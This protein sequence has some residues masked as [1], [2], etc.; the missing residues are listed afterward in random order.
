M[1][2]AERDRDTPM[3]RDLL[4]A[5]EVLAMPAGSPVQLVAMASVSQ[6][7][8]ADAHHGALLLADETKGRLALTLLLTGLMDLPAGLS[9]GLSDTGTAAHGTEGH[10]LT[11]VAFALART[12]ER[13]LMP[14]HCAQCADEEAAQVMLR[15]YVHDEL[16]EMGG[17]V[18][19]PDTRGGAR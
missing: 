1:S 12:G 14:L 8:H 4:A 10:M 7:S 17:P 9:Q 18:S 5:W 11:L 6:G 3:G 19:I 16:A 15:L 13:H 2:R